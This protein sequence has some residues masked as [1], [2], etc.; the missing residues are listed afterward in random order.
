MGFD[1][2]FVE[3]VTK[4]GLSR[5]VENFKKKIKA[6]SAAL[7][8]FSGYG[9]QANRQTFVIPVDAQLWTEPDVRRDGTTLEAILSE[10][11][12]Q[13]AAVKMAVID[14][15]RKNPYERR[16]RSASAGLAPINAPKDSLVIYAAGLGQVVNENVDDQGLFMTELLRELRS[17]ATTAEEVFTRTR[18]GV[19]RASDAEQVPWVSSSLVESFYFV[20]TGNPTAERRGIR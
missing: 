15:A 9:I 17:P 8:F 3:N 5:A 1:V 4:Q 20:P 10:M 6:G 19:S 11:N 7:F 16:F 18:I 13:G 12:G 14:A 2:D